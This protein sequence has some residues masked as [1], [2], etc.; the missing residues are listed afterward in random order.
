M[1]SYQNNTIEEYETA[2]P[3]GSAIM[4]PPPTTT[5]MDHHS[6]R[7]VSV[8]IVAGMMLLVV[9]GGTVWRL[10]DIGSSYTTA[11]GV[12][13]GPEYVPCFP[14]E[15]STADDDSNCCWTTHIY[16]LE[17]SNR[18]DGGERYL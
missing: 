6:K 17:I 9:A 1:M 3:L 2:V 12:P 10:Q 4:P 13:V 7:M 16:L 18:G 5:T 8:A 14:C 15:W 11:V